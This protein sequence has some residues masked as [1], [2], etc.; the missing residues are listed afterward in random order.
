MFDKDKLKEIANQR[1]RWE[2]TTLQ[3]WLKQTPERKPEFQ[4]HSGTSIKRLY[5]PED[6]KSLDYLRDLGFPGEYPFTRG[7]HATM[8]RG[9]LWT[10]RM[11]AGFGTA[12]D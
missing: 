3:N 8:Y 10:M 11:F 9:R 1:A 2:Q 12:K 5:T 4:N 6:V 7:V